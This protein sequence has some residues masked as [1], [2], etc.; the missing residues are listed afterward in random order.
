MTLLG[1]FSSSFGQNL[2]LNPSFEKYHNCPVKL[3]NLEKDVLDWNMPTLGSTDYFNGCSTVM[4]TPENF[5]GKQPANF[6]VGYVG[7]YMYAP[8][9]YRE[10]IQAKLSSTLKKGEQYRISFY[11]SL[12]ER[13]D[14]AVKEFGIRFT[15][16][17][18][19]VE[20]SKV[21][22][23]LHFSRLKGDTSKAVEISYSKYYSDEIKWVKLTTE[24]IA[25]GTENYMIIGNFKNNKRTQKYQTK[26][27]ITKGSYY[28][29]DMVSVSNVNSKPLNYNDIS[30]KEYELDSVHIFKDVYFNSNKSK[31]RGK[32]QQEM[33]ALLFYLKTNT[34]IDIEIFGHTDSIGTDSFN[35]KL[36][37]K[38]ADEVVAYL[39][40]NGI[41]KNRITFQG[42]GSLKPIATNK[43]EAGRFLN[44]RVEFVLTKTD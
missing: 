33:E 5:N 8:N 3:G 14:F 6:G 21:L 32:Y 20:T 2:V 22:S 44:R 43:T 34:A 27:K 16:F 42:F 37:L 19:D 18:V 9:D 35:K 39:T 12:A 41:Q 10:Y 25:S 17:P 1:M 30:L 29:L 26:R 36:S 40:K 38:R 4:G 15:E 7:F 13:S 31:I 24:F 28:Y 11:V 23:G